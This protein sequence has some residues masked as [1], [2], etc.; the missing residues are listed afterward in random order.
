MMQFRAASQP[1]QT[2]AKEHDKHLSPS[3]QDLPDLEGS[4]HAFERVYRE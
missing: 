1:T 3:D 4:G 2:I